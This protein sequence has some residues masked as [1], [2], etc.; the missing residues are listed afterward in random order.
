MIIVC[1]IFLY[2]T[3][4]TDFCIFASESAVDNGLIWKNL[5]KMCRSVRVLN[6]LPEHMTMIVVTHDGEVNIQPGSSYEK[7]AAQIIQ[8]KHYGTIR[9]GR[10]AI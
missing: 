9:Y 2:F 3:Y 8:D 5:W 1:H 7:V 6:L 10:I 4:F